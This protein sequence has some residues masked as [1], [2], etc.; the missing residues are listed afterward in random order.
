MS[1]FSRQSVGLEITRNG[2]R[3]VAVGGGSGKL[4]LKSW[5]TGEFAPDVMRPSFREPNLM[6]RGTFSSTLK[7][8]WLRL[9]VR[10]NRVDVALPDTVG[11]T[12][13]IDLDTRLRSKSEGLDLIRWKLKKNLPV[14]VG[15]V[16]LDYQV[17]EER[18]D[19]TLSVLA[20]I[21][22]R[23]V[24]SQYEEALQDAGLVPINIEFSSFSLYRL[25]A[26]RLDLAEQY[27]VVILH[28]GLLTLMLFRGGVLDFVRTKELTGG[29][30]DAN[31]LFRELNSSFLVYREKVP[32]QYLEELFYLVHDEDVS[33]FAAVLAEA[34]GVE[35]K[36]L[37]IARLLSTEGGVSCDQHTISQLAAAAGA[38]L[39]SR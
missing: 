18:E 13:L 3:L 24:V 12:M 39:R 5:Q 33:G 9:L 28:G 27:G 16:H 19:G 22:S 10:E 34:S 4:S 29:G 15:T 11:R 2:F 37:D 20:A 32:G 36:R 14:D 1:I 25:F 21:I 35:P 8:A 17:L 38:A 7:D 30:M 31:R 23:D 26:D 6:D